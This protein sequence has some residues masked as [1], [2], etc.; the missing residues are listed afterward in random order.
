MNI[1]NDMTIS[2][3]THSWFKYFT[4]GGERY[5]WELAKAL[6]KYAQVNLVTF[7]TKRNTCRVSDNLTIEEFPAFCSLK[8][9]IDSFNP[10]PLSFDFLEVLDKSNIVHINQFGILISSIATWYCHFR[11]K[12]I[13][14][15]YHGGRGR[16][17]AAFTPYIGTWID[18]FLF[19][20]D[21]MRPMFSKFGRSCTSVYVGVDTDK[22]CPINQQRAKGKIL[23]VG[24][25][26]PIKGIEFL[27]EAVQSINVELYVIGPAMDHQY[28]NSLKQ[29]DVNRKVTFLG[30][31]DD[32]SLVYHYNTAVVTIMPSVYTKK[33]WNCFPESD[34]APNVILESMSCG[35]PVIGTDIAGI[36]EL[37]CNGETGFIIPPS[38]SDGIRDSI[39]YCLANPTEVTKMGMLARKTVL[40]QFT[41][42]AVAQRC[43]KTYKKYI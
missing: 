42:D 27:V 29:R 28:L 3:L 35:T 6:S 15:S 32:N 14:A 13:F 11:K 19:V 4:G 30:N 23:F 16:M 36:P 8:P 31:Q 5:P 22:F 37:I 9:I 7:A 24:R 12:P 43:I 2:I 18:E 39:A 10:L 26:H 41:W 40:D 17:F 21:Y 25:I 1:K 34:L 33:W 20:C 38:N